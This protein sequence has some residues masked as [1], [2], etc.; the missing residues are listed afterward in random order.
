MDGFGVP[1]YDPTY[2]TIEFAQATF[3]RNDGLNKIFYTTYA[4]EKCGDRFIGGVE[5][6]ELYGYTENV[7]CPVNPDYYLK[8]SLASEV[9][10]FF[11]ATIVKC[12]GDNCKSKEEILTKIESGRFNIMIRNSYVSHPCFT[13]ELS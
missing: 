2:F 4:I 12:Q 1:F 9:Y 11:Q 6:Y 8:G 5:F 10:E 3:N 7:Y 13:Y